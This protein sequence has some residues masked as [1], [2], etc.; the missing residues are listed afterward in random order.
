MVCKYETITV[1]SPVRG[2]IIRKRG[3]HPYVA[4]EGACVSIGRITR[5]SYHPRPRKEAEV[6][7]I[8]GFVVKKDF[9]FISF[10]GRFM[11]MAQ[12]TS[13]VEGVPL[14]PVLFGGT[15]YFGRHVDIHHIH[16]TI[17]VY[18]DNR[19]FFKG[20]KGICALQSIAQ[21]FATPEICE[22]ALVH[23]GVFSAYIGNGVDTSHGCY[24]EL[25]FAKMFKSMRLVQRGFDHNL[26]IRLRTIQFD[27][28]EMP[29]LDPAHVPKDVDVTVSGS[30]SIEPYSPDFSLRQRSRPHSSFVDRAGVEPDCRAGGSRVLQSSDRRVSSVL[31]NFHIKSHTQRKSAQAGCRRL[32]R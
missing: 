10:Q 3:S 21:T 11:D 4:G 12:G 20:C 22:N 17:Y 25:M 7:N 16:G 24:F 29:W 30:P 31:L 2:T 28:N 15:K 9:E 8:S 1:T 32:P 14:S 5:L 13:A 23:M 18:Q 19:I 26:T 6:V 27:L